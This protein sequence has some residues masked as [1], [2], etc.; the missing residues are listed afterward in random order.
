MTLTY[1]LVHADPVPIWLV[2]GDGVPSIVDGPILDLLKALEPFNGKTGIEF[3]GKSLD[4]LAAVWKNGI[5]VSPTDAVIFCADVEKAHEYANLGWGEPGPGL[6]LALHCGH[7]ERSFKDL[8]ADASTNEIAEVQ[9]TYRHKY[10]ATDGRMRFSRLA[11]QE[12]LNYEEAYGYWIPGNAKDAL[13]AV[14]IF[15]GSS[16]VADSLANFVTSPVDGAVANGQGCAEQTAS[17]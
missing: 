8:P 17:I 5:D 14:F 12:N 1:E 15:G 11:E 2:Q 10:T 7:L 4:H 16:E 3:R 13:L 9:R 6:I